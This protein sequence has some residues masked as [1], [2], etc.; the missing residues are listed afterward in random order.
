MML[1]GR[2]ALVTGAGSGIGRAVAELFAAEGAAVALAGLSLPA[3]EAAA[4]AIRQRT[5][6]AAAALQLDVRSEEQVERAVA[7]VL[8][9]FGRIDILVNSAGVL[10]PVPFLE[11]TAEEWDRQMDTNARG[12]FLVSRAVARDMVRRRSGRIIH[13]ASDSG[14]AAFPGESAYGPSKA[15]LL[16]LTRSIALEL[17]PLGIR[18]NAVCPGATRTP[19]L[20]Q[21][22]LTSPDKEPAIAAS[23]PLGRI[24]EPEDIAQVALFFASPL[25]DWVTGEHLLATGG[26][27]M[28]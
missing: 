22:I 20:E 25:S 3:L 13:I 8:R 11:L 17:G 4:A 18:C 16:A 27:I 1:K 6:A 7:E 14:V 24:A 10:K 23:T 19:L 12:A 2:V 9:R 28:G 21:N 15:A 26:N 5:G